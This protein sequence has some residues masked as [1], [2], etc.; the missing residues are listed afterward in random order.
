MNGREYPGIAIYSMDAT[1]TTKNRKFPNVLKIFS[2]E[3]LSNCCVLI[4]EIK[5]DSAKKVGV[6]LNSLKSRNI[7]CLLLCLLCYISIACRVCGWCS[8]SITMLIAGQIPLCILLLARTHFQFLRICTVA[9]FYVK[10][11][12]AA[13][14]IHMQQQPYR[15]EAFI[16][17]E[18]RHYFSLCLCMCLSLCLSELFLN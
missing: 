8:F 3:L 2:D 17:L 10:E 16:P 4:S 13:Q 12:P 11:P 14:S 1:L 7:Q 5:S 18:Q 6:Y 9:Y 15:S